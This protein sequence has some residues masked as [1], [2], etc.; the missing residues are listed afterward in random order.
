LKKRRSV[1]VIDLEG[2]EESN[3]DFVKLAGSNVDVWAL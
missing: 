1:V 2:F 3:A